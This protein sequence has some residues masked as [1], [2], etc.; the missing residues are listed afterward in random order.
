MLAFQG[1]A[2]E[3]NKANFDGGNQ[4]LFCEKKSPVYA[5]K[6]KKKHPF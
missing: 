2:N 5:D 1:L 3:D 6:N 4:E